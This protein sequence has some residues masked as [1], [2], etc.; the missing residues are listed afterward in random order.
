MLDNIP[1]PKWRFALVIDGGIVFGIRVFLFGWTSIPG[2][3]VRDSA[4]AA[5]TISGLRELRRV[6]MN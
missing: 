2:K 4:N 3:I 5:G 1:V 6:H